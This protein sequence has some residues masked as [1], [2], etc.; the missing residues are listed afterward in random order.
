[1]L[2]RTPTGAIVIAITVNGSRALVSGV[3]RNGARNNSGGSVK[4]AKIIVAATMHRHCCQPRSKRRRSEIAAPMVPADTPWMSQ[5]CCRSSMP[6]A[7]VDRDRATRPRRVVAC[8]V[9]AYPAHVRDWWY[10]ARF[11]GLM[12]WMSHSCRSM[13]MAGT[14]TPY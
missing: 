10:R 14:S 2:D 6:L 1:M 4:R 12:A 3:Q 7:W 9:R 13:C 11:P 8:G 5:L